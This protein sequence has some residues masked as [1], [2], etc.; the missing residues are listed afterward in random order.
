MNVVV[1]GGDLPFSRR[2]RRMRMRRRWSHLKLATRMAMVGTQHEGS[3]TVQSLCTMISKWE[4]GHMMPNEYN[5][6]LLAEA[7]SAEVE[8]LGLKPDPDFEF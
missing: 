8:D 3:A 2:L 1:A 5:L 4:N 7:L 6:H